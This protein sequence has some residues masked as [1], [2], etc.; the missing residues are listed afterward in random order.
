MSA[1]SAIEVPEKSQHEPQSFWSLIGGIQ[2]C[3]RLS[4]F[5]SVAGASG[6]APTSASPFIARNCPTVGALRPV[7]YDFS[8]AG[9]VPA[10]S[11]AA[12]RP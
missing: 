4:H 6:V 10:N 3:S 9:A 12:S 8:W 1:T 5:G 11:R 7:G 2:P